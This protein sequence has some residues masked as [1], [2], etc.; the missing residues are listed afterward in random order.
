MHLE[1]NTF[2]LTSVGKNDSKIP[3]AEA[4]VGPTSRSGNNMPYDGITFVEVLDYSESTTNDTMHYTGNGFGS[5]SI[6]AASATNLTNKM[7]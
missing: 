2:D 6:E 5:V 1:S 7:V 4:V 3:L